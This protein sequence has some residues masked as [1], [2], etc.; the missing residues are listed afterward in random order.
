MYFDRYE[1]IPSPTDTGKVTWSASAKT[2]W[3]DQALAHETTRY[4]N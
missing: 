2:S 1:N 4:W 3:L